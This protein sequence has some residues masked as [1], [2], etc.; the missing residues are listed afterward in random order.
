[1]REDS[2]T[3]SRQGTH[4]NFVDALLPPELLAEAGD[5]V[6]ILG[7]D[8]SVTYAELVRRIDACAHALSSLGLGR[9]SVVPLAMRDQPLLMA[10]FLGAVKMGAVPILLSPRMA[11]ADL[12]AVVKEA[13]PALLIHD[14]FAAE[15]VAGLPCPMLTADALAER[16]AGPYPGFI[17]A[18]LGPND[19][20]FRVYSSGTTGKPKGIVHTHKH[21]WPMA[22]YLR[23][24]L[25][26]APGE[27][28][29]C[30]SKLSFAY[31]QGN[32]F[33]GPLQ[34]GCTIILEKDWPTAESA[35]ATIERHRPAIVYSTP[36][37][38]RGMLALLDGR[39]QALSSVRRF[40][41]AGEA[42]PEPLGEA[43]RKATGRPI[44]NA[45]GCSETIALVV[46]MPPDAVRPG[47][48]GV[49]VSGGELR[50]ERFEGEPDGSG[51][52]GTLWIRHPFLADGYDNNP[53]QTAE[54]FR[55]GWYAT[56][57]VF[58]QDADGYWHH[59]GRQ[60]GLIKVAGQWVQLRE[61]EDIAQSSGAV[62]E[63]AAVLARD[64]NGFGRVGLFVVAK[65]EL[66]EEAC[67]KRVQ[68]AFEAS[69]PKHKW[70]RWVRPIDALPRTSTGKVQTYRLREMIEEP[71][72]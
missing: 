8:E 23:N 55:D 37:L 40:V 44:L 36:T 45:Y 3:V 61:I 42:L 6:A 58:M 21:P 25:G 5:V 48:T 51:A 39:E 26:I 69:A 64:A 30:T 63:V 1:M 20:A 49:S 9:G 62:S 4:M 12:A 41:S 38:Y 34:T 66:S 17:A 28:I 53:E 19:E 54:R 18:E 46:A 11:A 7:T 13:K 56:G 33:L 10:A 70:P 57:D 35:L 27:R 71:T 29:F 15:A 52:L 47:A 2:L 72:A 24:F 65:D 32:G 60:D 22:A 67:V 43:W 68:T 16:A 50:L 14:D 31:A 59:R